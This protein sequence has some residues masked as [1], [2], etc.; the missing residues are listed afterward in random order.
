LSLSENQSPKRGPTLHLMRVVYS[1]AAAAAVVQV[2]AEAAA[3]AANRD[4]RNV[5]DGFE[6][7][8]TV[9]KAQ[10]SGGL[11]VTSLVLTVRGSSRWDH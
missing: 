10:F 7:V 5:V 4:T 3:A 9:R 6:T 1:T 2:T 11:K 8:G